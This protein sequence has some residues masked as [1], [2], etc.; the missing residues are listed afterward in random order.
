VKVNWLGMPNVIAGHEIVPEFI[1][2]DAKPE[3]IA[4]VARELLE[5][6]AKRQAMRRE[7]ANVV[8]TLSGTGASERAAQLIL[9][10]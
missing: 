7:L 1:Q 4:A 2:H 6:E 5:N 8:A 3:R 9:S 10:S